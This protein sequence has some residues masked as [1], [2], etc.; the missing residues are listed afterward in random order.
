MGRDLS[1]RLEKLE[2]GAAPLDLP[3]WPIE[4]QLD[5]VLEALR[6]HRIAGTAQ[7]AT[8]REIRLV[9][10]AC[11]GEEITGHVRVEDLPEGVREHFERM[12]PDE[13]P[14]RERWLH[15]NWQALKEQREHWRH[16]FS[17]EQV[18]TRR[19]ES[20][21]RDRELL[22]RNRGEGAC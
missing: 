5:D 1:R 2:E 4:D 7:L 16:W 22:A 6:I 14:A 8:D 17:E 3:D 12:A 19:E 9:A 13:Q 15:A 21:R 11:S 10:M 18:R 20:K